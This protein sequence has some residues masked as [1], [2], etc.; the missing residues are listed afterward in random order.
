MC[1]DGNHEPLP[2]EVI[3][4]RE[5]AERPTIGKRVAADVHGPA[6]VRRDGCRWNDPGHAHVLPAPVAL[7]GEMLLAVEPLG[8]VVIGHQP[9][10]REESVELRTPPPR[11]LPASTHRRRRTGASRAGRCDA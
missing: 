8:S 2:G 1:V 10:A 11:P 7:H 6:L 9:L 5:R 3:E 4:D